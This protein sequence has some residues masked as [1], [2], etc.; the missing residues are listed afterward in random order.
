MGKLFGTDGVRGVA[1]KDPM[2]PQS[3][4]RL[5]F[6]AG[7]E[8]RSQS[9]SPATC[10]IGRDTRISGE[11]LEGALLAGLT[12]SGVNVLRAGV[13]PTPAVSQLVREFGAAFG[14]VISAS[15]NPFDDNGVKFFGG[16]GQ[17]LPD[18]VE[19]S[20][21]KTFE[22]LSEQELTKVQSDLT[23]PRM[24]NGR[25][26]PEAID[27]YCALMKRAFGEG[28]N[29]AGM[30][31]VVDCANGASHLTTPRV[32]TSLGA[33]VVAFNDQPDGTNINAGCGSLHFNA[34]QEAVRRERAHVGISHDGD[35]DRVILADENG[36]LVDGD[37]VLGIVGCHLHAKGALPH[38]AVVGTVMSN[39]GFLVAMRRL[40]IGVFR[41][42]VG[43][44]YVKELMDK[45][46][47][48]L[49]G[50]QSGHIIFSRHS[51]TGD[52]LLTALQVLRVMVDEGRPLSALHSFLTRFPQVLINVRV[53]EKTSLDS[54]SGLKNAISE[55][56]KS[57]GD[58]GRV[59]VRYSGTEPLLRVMVEGASEK[60]V[61][62]HAQ[63][64][65]QIVRNQIGE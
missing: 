12:S 52:G 41:A 53:R 28:K 62:T 42:P 14:A 31:I 8:L 11:M 25:A 13:L 51:P 1:N 61:Q 32:L 34:V 40:G 45:E 15:H 24:G 26:L 2:T 19:L 64:L 7:V 9:C 22:R 3:V 30:K 20:I 23:G 54:I 35:A 44:R 65:A 58:E 38:D 56:E 17:K 63:F 10:I 59:F 50:E 49:G 36:Q 48:V 29:L 4:M 5:G 57:L 16:D 46:G 47:V 37:F 60:D 6:A 55:V 39:L 43:D 27:R 18:S 33:E 21:E